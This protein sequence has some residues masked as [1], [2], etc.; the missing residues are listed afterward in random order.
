MIHIK[1]KQPFL[2]NAILQKET[3]QM[4]WQNGK[5]LTDL[6]NQLMGEKD[7]WKG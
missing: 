1:K 3:V 2:K 7:G 4:N 5:R 6:Q